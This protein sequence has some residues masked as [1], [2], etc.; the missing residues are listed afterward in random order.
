MFTNCIFAYSVVPS[1]APSGL[2]V[3][4]VTSSNITIHWEL[5]PCQDQNGDIT[6]YS[7]QYG[8]V[9]SDTSQTVVVPGGENNQTVISDLVPSTEYWIQVAAVNNVGTGDYSTDVVQETDGEF[10][11]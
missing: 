9:D 6:G 7:V 1:A 10:I 8:E 4:A 5:L 11:L 2:N 3:S